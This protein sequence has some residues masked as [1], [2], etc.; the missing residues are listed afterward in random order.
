MK[1]EYLMLVPE[2]ADGFQATI[3]A[4]RSLGERD[5]VSFHTLSLLEDRCLLLL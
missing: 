2:T 3:D 4:L 5:S 1:G